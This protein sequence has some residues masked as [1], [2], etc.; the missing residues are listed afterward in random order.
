LRRPWRTRALSRTASPSPGT[1]TADAAADE[2]D[3]LR[4]SKAASCDSHSR[5]T[6]A[7]DVEAATEAETEDEEREET[8]EEGKWGRRVEEGGAAKSD[9]ESRRPIDE[10]SST[11]EAKRRVDA[12]RLPLSS[13]S[14]LATSNEFI[15][16]A[17]IT[18]CVRHGEGE[19]ET[20]ELGTNGR[21]LNRASER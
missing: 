6:A 16:M 2:D 5:A 14:I 19:D 15:Y 17:N 1:R 13:L 18:L 9:L 12:H 7:S 11:I 8:W 20:W 4:R 21:E 10:C 3:A